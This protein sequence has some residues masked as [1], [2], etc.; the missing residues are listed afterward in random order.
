M[1][2][3]CKKNYNEYGR[4]FNRNQIYEIVSKYDTDYFILTPDHAADDFIEP[5]GLW[6]RNN[7]I[8]DFFYTTQELRKFKL[9]KLNDR[10]E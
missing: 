6:F 10:L 9:K 7:T 1:K 3:V 2:I 8:W 4:F 5:K